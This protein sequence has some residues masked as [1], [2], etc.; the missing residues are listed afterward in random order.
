MIGHGI[1]L[2]T[3]D[4]RDRLYELLEH[5]HLPL[6]IGSRFVR[7]IVIVIVAD[8][9]SLILA[10]VPEL[11]ARFA[12]VFTSIQVMADIVFGLEYFARLWSVAGHGP[13][14]VSPLRNRL[15]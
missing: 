7:M 13:R 3:P 10:S 8:V 11:D 15:D 4:L 5:D 6:S 12:P 14:K 2:S 9:L 1:H